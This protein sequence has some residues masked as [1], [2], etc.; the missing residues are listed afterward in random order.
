MPLPPPP[1]YR[2]RDQELYQA[3]RDAFKDLHVA[4]P[5]SFFAEKTPQQ[6]EAW[7]LEQG[8]SG[9]ERARKAASIILY[10]H[11]HRCPSVNLFCAP[12]GSG[13]TYLWT[14]LQ[15]AD[16]AIYIFDASILT[17]QGY[18]GAKLESCFRSIQPLYRSQAIIVLD[19]FEKSLY[20]N[21]GQYRTSDQLQSEMLRC[22]NH[23]KVFFAGESANEYVEYDFKNVT[24]ILLGAFN[25][26]L[27]AKSR[28]ETA[29]GFGGSPK[30]KLTYDDLTFSID[31]VVRHT[32][33]KEEL[34]G[35]IDRVVSMSPLTKQE[36]FMILLDYVDNTSYAIAKEIV[37]DHDVLFRI[38][39]QATAKNYG[40][41][42]AKSQVNEIIDNL[43]YEDC[44]KQ[45]LVYKPKELVYE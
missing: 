5:R 9:Q 3:G 41:R 36:I 19:E 44:T 28:S 23:D 10:R 24:F 43:L 39:E 20:K 11:Y 7:L 4:P 15:Q 12:S 6:I 17:P 40:A 18:R 31:D 22:F 35:R 25:D 16:P 45:T 14:L 38:A 37:I 1:Q 34:G 13:K 8:Y 29:A 2:G 32:P 42:W 27:K 33:L 30:H 21:D 26:L